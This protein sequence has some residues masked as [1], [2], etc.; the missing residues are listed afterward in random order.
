LTGNKLLQEA[1][2][3]LRADCRE[4]DR[5]GRLGGDEFVFILPEHE[6]SHLPELKRRIDRAVQ[7][8]SRDVC[9]TN[10]VSMSLGCAFYPEDGITAEELLSVADRRMYEAKEEYHSQVEF[11]KILNTGR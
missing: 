9:G 2:S 3:K 7:E 6:Q 8:A 10:E 4:Y 11:R 1:A 5:V